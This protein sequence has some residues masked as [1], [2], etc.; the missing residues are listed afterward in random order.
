VR[1]VIVDQSSLAYFSTSNLA[2]SLD[3]HTL[4]GFQI[5]LRPEI[6]LDHHPS[7][8]IQEEQPVALGADPQ[9]SALN[10]NRT[11]QKILTVGQPA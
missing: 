1:P 10:S 2:T 9:Q 8:I 4:A 6:H 5:R 3:T 7:G 11:G